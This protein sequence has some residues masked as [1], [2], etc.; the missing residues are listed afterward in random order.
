M[1]LAPHGK[2][3]LSWWARLRGL[4][5]RPPLANDGSEALLISPCASIHTFGMSYPLDV[6]FLDRAGSVL[7]VRERIRPWRACMQKG[8]RSVIEFHAGA[9]QRLSIRPGDVIEW[10]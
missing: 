4:L 7:G 10:R 6:V 5:F 3:A 8:A 1:C 2:A 9:V